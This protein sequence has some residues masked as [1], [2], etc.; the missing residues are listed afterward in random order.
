MEDF[1][2]DSV[3]LVSCEED[4]IPLDYMGL[5]S[6]HDREFDKENLFLSTPAVFPEL[7]EPFNNIYMKVRNLND[8]NSLSKYDREFGLSFEKADR[9][10]VEAG[11][12][13]SF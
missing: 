2:T 6:R 3:A 9:L 1:E 10:G 12:K 4:E 7:P 5:T 8:D 13:I 11:I